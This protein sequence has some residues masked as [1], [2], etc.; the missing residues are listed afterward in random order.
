MGLHH[1]C[2][3]TATAPQRLWRACDEETLGLIATA[4][5]LPPSSINVQVA[6]MHTPRSCSAWQQPSS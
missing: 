4:D 1:L 5:V 2:Y 6:C 3:V